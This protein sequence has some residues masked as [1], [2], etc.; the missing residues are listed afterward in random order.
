MDTRATATTPAR[1]AGWMTD[2]RI[3]WHRIARLVFWVLLGFSLPPALHYLANGDWD[4][5]AQVFILPMS[6]GTTL[7]LWGVPS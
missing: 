3:N 7:W 6:F 4:G 1:S 2:T 5:A